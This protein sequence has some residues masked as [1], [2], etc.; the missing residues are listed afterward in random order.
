[1]VTPRLHRQQPAEKE[2]PDNGEELFQGSPPGKT[3]PPTQLQPHRQL[4]QSQ[5]LVGHRDSGMLKEIRITHSATTRSEPLI[6]TQLP[7]QETSRKASKSPKSPQYPNTFYHTHTQTH[8]F[9][10]IMPYF[11]ISSS[12]LDWK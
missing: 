7:G 12:K 5:T 11:T 2:R 4:F 10:T 3:P 6:S 8:I 1:M 9:S